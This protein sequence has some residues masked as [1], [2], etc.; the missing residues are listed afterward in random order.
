MYTSSAPGPA[1][2]RGGNP[3]AGVPPPQQQQPQ[4]LRGPT[5][6]NPGAPPQLATAATSRVGEMLDQVKAEYEAAIQQL[7][8]A[9]MEQLEMERK[10]QSQVVEMDQIQQ[11]LKAL[12][13]NH[14]RIRQQ[15]EED[16]LRMRRQLETGQVPQQQQVPPQ[17]QAVPA[18]LPAKRSRA[19]PTSGSMQEDSNS[20]MS[21]LVAAA[22]SSGRAGVA[23]SQQR[24]GSSPVRVVPVQPASRSLQQL[25]QQPPQLPPPPQGGNTNPPPQL[26]PLDTSQ[27]NTTPSSRRMPSINSEVN[28]KDRAASPPALK[29][30]KLNGSEPSIP[31]LNGNGKGALPSVSSTGNASTS[32]GMLPQVSKMNREQGSASTNSSP[33]AANQSQ[34]ASS[35][36]TKTESDNT[37]TSR[38][39]ASATS[40]LSAASGNNTTQKSS[41]TKASRLNWSCVYS[42]KT[43]MSYQE[44]ERPAAEM[45]QSMDHQSVVCCV[46]FSS[47]GTM[48]ASG[49][50][51]TAQVFDVKTGDRKFLV[52]RPAGSGQTPTSQSNAAANEPDDAYVRA[53]CFSPDCS[54]LVAG[55]PQNTIRVWDIA[56]N[57]EGPAMTG[58]ESEIYSLD[59][60]NDLIVSGSG[61][62]KVRL[63]DARNGQC[64]KIFGNESGG[65]SDGVTSVALSPDGRLLAA[66]SLDK[67]VRIWDTETAQLLDRLEGHSDSVYSIAFSPDGKNVISGSLDRNIMLWDVCAQGRTTTRPRMLFQGHKDFVLSVAYTPD[68]RWLMSGSKDRSVVFW[69][70]RSS[71]SVLTLTGYRNSVISVASSPASPYFAT[72][73]GDCFAVIWKYQCQTF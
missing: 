15:Y 21:N 31:S 32:S 71:R 47:D 38:P 44:S 55:M 1:R 8:M 60:V 20:L 58:H 10:I 41:N 48:M 62:R 51:K 72:G 70:P 6:G 54:K 3:N 19:P 2:G 12:E 9:K 11:S 42:S 16:M 14:R 25:G 4:Q 7:N 34:N 64:K 56:S 66:A 13:A 69:D 5:S 67:V 35:N 43:S 45:H 30:S 22:T 39:S 33:S 40:T 73:S 37:E 18:K 17:Q 50:H 53:V 68:G 59:Y 29:K 49:C 23:S 24:S 57:E 65:P 61:D 52:S 63:W 46:R 28:G 36:S 27:A 26:S